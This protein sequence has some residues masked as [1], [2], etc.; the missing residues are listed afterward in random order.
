M[1]LTFIYFAILYL[2]MF[3]SEHW[4]VGGLTWSRGNFP[5]CVCVCVLEELLEVGGWETRGFPSSHYE[6]IWEGS[7]LEPFCKDMSDCL[8]KD[9]LEGA[10]VLWRG[11]GEAGI[12]PWPVRGDLGSGE[13]EDPDD[14]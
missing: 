7:K 14:V 12:L 6:T 11:P 5:E 1:F 10:K 13:K 8:G 2:E 3:F 9:G 4:S